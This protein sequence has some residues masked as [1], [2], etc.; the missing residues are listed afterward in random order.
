[1]DV[2][3]DA[4]LLRRWA[5]SD[6]VAG[7]ALFQRYYGAMYRFFV[8]KV[9]DAPTVEDLVQETFTRLIQVAS[10]YASRSTVRTF[11]FGVARMVLLEHY[12]ERGHGHVSDDVIGMTSV[13]DLGA[14]PSSVAAAREEL[15]ILLDALRRIAFEKQVILELYYF[16]DLS[17]PELADFMGVSEST[18][19][20]RIRM[21]MEGLRDTI[22]R[23]TAGSPSMHSL[24]TSIEGWVHDLQRS[25]GGH[26]PAHATS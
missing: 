23:N 24:L 7:N 13:V 6:R 14:G 20:S 16:E 26:T 22:V 8:N 18:A 5:E 4:E 21:A 9:R 2:E 19:R 25:L 12:R 17:G 10:R 11:V 1:V 15:R 3:S